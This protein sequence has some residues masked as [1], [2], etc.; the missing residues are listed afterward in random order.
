VAEERLR[1]AIVGCGVIASRHVVA[2]A[3]VDDVAAGAID[4]YQRPIDGHWGLTPAP[5]GARAAR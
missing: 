1:L 2:F 5:A 3:R 4:A